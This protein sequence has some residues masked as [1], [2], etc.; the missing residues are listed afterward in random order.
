[1]ENTDSLGA[2]E[3]GACLAAFASAFC[4]LSPALSGALTLV[5]RRVFQS[6]G[7]NVLTAERSSD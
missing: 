6:S 3:L 2:T 4:S 5:A 1:M 7:S